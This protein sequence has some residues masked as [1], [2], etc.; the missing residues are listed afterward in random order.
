MAF[1]IFVDVAST[2]LHQSDRKVLRS[3][4]TIDL[5]TP[6]QN[7]LS[8]FVPFRINH[9]LGWSA[10]LFRIF[11]RNVCPFLFSVFSYFQSTA[12]IIG[13]TDIG[14]EFSTSISTRF[15]LWNDWWYLHS[16]YLLFMKESRALPNAQLYASATAHIR[17]WSVAKATA[18]TFSRLQGH[19]PWPLRGAHALRAALAGC[20]F[21]VSRVALSCRTGLIDHNPV[22]HRWVLC[23]GDALTSLLPSRTRPSRP[24]FLLHLSSRVGWAPRAIKT[25]I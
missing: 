7:I 8:S 6:H 13:R 25:P 23:L 14:N 21:R 18:S 19:I 10:V 22:P 2:C 5:R 20:G 1:Q 17:A 16:F 4:I 9:Y 11:V 12:R 3:L 15:C 24:T